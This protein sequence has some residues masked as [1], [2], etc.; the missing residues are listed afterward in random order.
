MRKAFRGALPGVLSHVAAAPRALPSRHAA[1]M[2]ALQ[3]YDAVAVVLHWAMAVALVAQFALGWWMV[4]LP[5]SGGVQRAWFNLHKSTGL[6]LAALALA[7][8]AWRLRHPAPPLPATEA[9]LQRIA[10]HVTHAGLY[11]CILLLPLTGYLGSS[12]SGYP[13]R[14]FGAALPAWGWKWPAAKGLLA[15]LHLA[16]TW[17]LA[18]LVLAHVG[19]ALLHLLRRDGMLRRMWF[20]RGRVRDQAGGPP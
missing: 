10:A 7:R 2:P 15:S 12:F 18:M 1:H 9:R 20:S 16:L 6:V 3:R 13:V 19:A 11:V 14:F 5:D 4:N 8:L 17:L